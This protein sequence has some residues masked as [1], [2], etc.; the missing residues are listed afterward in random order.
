[1]TKNKC[2]FFTLLAVFF[3]L[4]IQDSVASRTWRVA[5]ECSETL[6]NAFKAQLKAGNGLIPVTFAQKQRV[7][8]Q[9]KRNIKPHTGVDI[10]VIHPNANIEQAKIS[11]HYQRAIEEY[12]LPGTR[13]VSVVRQ[14]P[15]LLFKGWGKNVICDPKGNIRQ[16]VNG[17]FRLGYH[18]LEVPIIVVGYSYENN[19]ESLFLASYYNC[20]FCPERN[21]QFLSYVY[22]AMFGEDWRAILRYFDRMRNPHLPPKTG[23]KVFW[24][25]PLY[26]RKFIETFLEFHT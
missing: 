9:D 7:Q 25:N 5:R 3:T 8:Y 11:A 18:P 21:A 16:E 14:Y 13:V 22:E 10:M 6:V 19:D 12:D 23:K 26:H 1:M 24:P 20:I 17:I 2:L 15:S 4:H